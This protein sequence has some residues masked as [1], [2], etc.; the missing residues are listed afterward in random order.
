MVD[1]AADNG[2]SKVTLAVLG[3]RMTNLQTSV[4]ALR[5]EFRSYCEARD[6]EFGELERRV[7]TSENDIARQGEKL[8]ILSSLNAV[9]TTIA[10][11]IAGA[12][13]TR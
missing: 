13:G 10:A 11:A 6:R 4:D 12:L 1:M 5:A 9:W 8:T 3:E 7:R 2:N